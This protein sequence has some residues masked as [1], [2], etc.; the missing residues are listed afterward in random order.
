MES[1][2]K[3]SG[4][5]RQGYFQARQRE[6]TKHEETA[7]ILTK[8]RHARL[9]H[10]RMGSRPLHK[11]LKIESMGIN[12]FERMLSEEGLGIK[13]KKNRYKTTDGYKYKKRIVNLLNGKIIKN[14]NEVWVSDIT[15]FQVNSMHFYIIMILDVYSRKILSC[16]IYENMSADN[17]LKVLKSA[18]KSRGIANYNNQLIHHSDKG[19]QYMSNAYKSI[20]LKHG[21]QISAAE[22]SLQNAYAERINGTIKNDYLYF[23]STENLKVLRKHLKRC[24]EL[25]N[26]ER[27]HSQLNYLTPN[28]F[29]ESL[30]VNSGKP[31][32]LHDFTQVPV[33]EFFEG[34]QQSEYFNEKG[35]EE[36]SFPTVQSYSS[37]GCSPAEPFSA[38]LCNTKVVINKISK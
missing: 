2:Y 34:I 26:N 37:K 21:I 16:G 8:V 28:Q 31:M 14:I 1:I 9:S 24:V 11:M 32:K 19:S 33:L 7:M 30:K 13:R 35:S 17:N 4:I 12:K 6:A 3:V 25:Y 15:Y 27:P 38:S 29:E 10:P 18:L 36:P 23:H 22:N 20:L 5:S